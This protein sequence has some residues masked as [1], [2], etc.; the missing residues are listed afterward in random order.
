MH[1][2]ITLS[3]QM[4]NFDLLGNG[5]N[6]SRVKKESIHQALHGLTGPQ[7]EFV[8]ICL[9]QNKEDRPS[10]TTLLKHPALQEV[11]GL[12]FYVN[13]FRRSDVV[14]WPGCIEFLP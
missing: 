12:C 9:R 14:N 10:A 4:L 11:R 8:D 5:E 7:Q 2:Y 3:T 6:P 1:N 13:S